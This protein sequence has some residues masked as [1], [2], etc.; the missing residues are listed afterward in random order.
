MAFE[1]LKQEAAGQ[2]LTTFLKSYHPEVHS[3]AGFYMGYRMAALLFEEHAKEGKRLPEIIALALHN[4]EGI[5]KGLD[6][7]QAEQL[8]KE[9]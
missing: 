4:A 5:K 9:G 8:A 2:A 1:N 3:V 6:I 7:V